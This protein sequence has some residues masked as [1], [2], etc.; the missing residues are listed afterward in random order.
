MNILLRLTMDFNSIEGIEDHIRNIALTKRIR[1]TE[2]F[3]DYDQ[4]RSGFVTGMLDSG[5]SFCYFIT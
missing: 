1:P 2:F 3:I 5:E 4:L